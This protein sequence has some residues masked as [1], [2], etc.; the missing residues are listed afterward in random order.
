MTTGTETTRLIILR[1]NSGSGKSSVAAG[2]RARFG[3]GIALVGQDNL[4]RVVLRERDV[5]GGAN[6]AL[7][8]LVARYAL[9]QGF[10]VMVEGIL[11]TGHYEAMLTDLAGEHRGV[12]RAYYLDVPFEETLA[13]HSTRP[14][15]G[16]FGVEEMR[17]WYRRLD[18]LTAVHEQVIPVESSLS[19]SVERI[20]ADTELLLHLNP[21]GDSGRSGNH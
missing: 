7:I 17:S 20:L 5:F 18:L 4:R 19:D 14:Q 9:D 3:R 21:G 15:A 12:T 16:D 2:V 13:R 8:G 10:H 11:H 6:I 1:G